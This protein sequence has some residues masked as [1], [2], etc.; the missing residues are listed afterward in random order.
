MKSLKTLIK[1]H[2]KTLDDLLHNINK[3]EQQRSNFIE[4]LTNMRFQTEQ[5]LKQYS[6]SEYAFMLDKYLQTM[7]NNEKNL[8]VQL[9]QVEQQ[10]SSLRDDLHTQ[11]TELKKFEIAYENRQKQ[12]RLAAE[13]LAVKSL[14]EFNNTRFILDK[15]K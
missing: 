9:H 3:L 12:E 10:I 2:K 1:L 8:T 13:K 4:S 6:G 15:K 11:F 5:E 14:D 7:Q